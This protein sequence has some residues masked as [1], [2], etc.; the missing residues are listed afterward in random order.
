LRKEAGTELI[1]SIPFPPHYNKIEKI[2]ENHRV[3][4]TGRYKVKTG[5]RETCFRLTPLD[6]SWF[7][8]HELKRLAVQ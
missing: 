8:S 4:I 3:G 6:F 2:G 5:K 1:G 7:I